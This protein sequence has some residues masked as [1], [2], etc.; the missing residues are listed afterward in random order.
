M[1]QR[2]PFFTT[3]LDLA[4]MSLAKADMGVFG[5]YLELVDEPLRPLGLRIVERHANA[6]ELV[7]RVTGAAI[8]AGDPVLRRSIELRNPY[9]DP[10]SRLQVELLRRLRHLPE[11]HDDRV[12][13]DYAVKLSLTG[14]SAGMRNTG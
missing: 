12:A 9:V 14:V 7:Q 6:T 3:M 8:L 2:W 5:A 4:Q 13:L 1:Y 11:D 10:I